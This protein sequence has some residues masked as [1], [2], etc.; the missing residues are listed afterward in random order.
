MGG[1]D[2]AGVQLGWANSF[3]ARC[4]VRMAPFSAYLARMSL[5]T[6]KADEFGA[7]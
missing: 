6:Y 7:H 2:G 3:A 1:A 4:P 5:E